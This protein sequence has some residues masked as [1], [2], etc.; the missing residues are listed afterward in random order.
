MVKIVRAF[1]EG[2]NVVV[3]DKFAHFASSKVEAA[4]VKWLV[5]QALAE[6]E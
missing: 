4:S 6:V 3:D 5:E 2:F 1:P